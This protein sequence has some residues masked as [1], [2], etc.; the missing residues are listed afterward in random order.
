MGLR[1]F[2]PLRCDHPEIGHRCL[3]YKHPIQSGDEIGHVPQNADDRES[4]TLAAHWR[5]IEHGFDR[6][7]Q[8]QKRL[9]ENSAAQALL[10][11]DARSILAKSV[12][13]PLT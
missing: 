8:A 5:C 1:K 10:R 13:S 4:A 6:W 12:A 9:S 7:S 3:L 2:R 11:M